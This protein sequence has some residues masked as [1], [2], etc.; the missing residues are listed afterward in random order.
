MGTAARKSRQQS[1]QH[2]A[3]WARPQAGAQTY[4]ALGDS[5]A[6]GVGVD[7]P[8]QSYVGLVAQR[9]AETWGET[10]RVANLAVSGAK[11]RDVL[12]TQIPQLAAM[13]TPDFLTC[14]IGGNDIAWTPVFRPDEFSRDIQA[15]A[16]H[17]PEVSVMGLVPQFV[18]WPYEGRARKA[19][20]AIHRAAQARGHAV[21]DIYAATKELSLRDYLRTFA[22]DRFHPN[23]SGHTLWADA[24]GEQLPRSQ[25]RVA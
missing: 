20:R 16:A 21:A 6:V 1:R 5:A 7:H 25:P 9:L 3:H 4:V 12:E 10:I 11:A 24:I 18:H 8:E 2:A 14:V 22:D 17:L 19:N 23:R 15:V 13:L